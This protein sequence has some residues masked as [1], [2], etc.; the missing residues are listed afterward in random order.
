[1]AASRAGSLMTACRAE[2]KVREWVH[3]AWGHRSESVA[4]PPPTGALDTESQQ[5]PARGPWGSS[6]QLLWDR[7]GPPGPIRPRSAKRP[8]PP[9]PPAQL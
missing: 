3:Y 6:L 2:A 1:M 5:A 7:H 8:E 9:F 4:C